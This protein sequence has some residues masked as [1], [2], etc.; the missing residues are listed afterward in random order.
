MEIVT[1]KT[2][3]GCYETS[4]HLR[5]SGKQEKRLEHKKKIFSVE[6]RENW[7]I[8]EKLSSKLSFFLQFFWKRN[9]DINFHCFFTDLKVFF[10]T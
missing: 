7:E 8:I 5:L 9:V 6:R 3:S 1:D 10:S 2:L 4:S